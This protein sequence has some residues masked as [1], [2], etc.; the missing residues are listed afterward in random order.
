MV[1]DH[2]AVCVP[3]VRATISGGRSAITGN[4]TLEELKF[5]EALLDNGVL[6]LE[7]T[8]VK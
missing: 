1:V 8:A 5:M 4:F 3:M 6:P 2:T 7:F